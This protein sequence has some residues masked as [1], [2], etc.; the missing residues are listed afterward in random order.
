MHTAL[1]E[2][3]FGLKPDFDGLRI[4]PCV[5]PSWTDFSVMRQ[6]R[7]ATYNIHFRNPQGVERGVKSIMVD[8]KSIQGNLLPVLSDGQT[9]EVEVLMVS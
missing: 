3:I 5:D 2:Y 4:D 7:G 6:F 8:G 9:H 1:L